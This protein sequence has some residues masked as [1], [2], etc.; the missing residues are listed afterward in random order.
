MSISA[1]IGRDREIIVLDEL[2]EHI[3]K[4]GGALVVRGDAGIGK[5]A[6][7]VEARA[8]AETR[9]LRTM[10]VTGV[11]SESVLPFAGL[12]QLMR[13]VLD[14]ASQL[15]EP[16]QKALLAAFGMA[17]IANSSRFLIALAALELFSDAAAQAPLLLLIEDAQWLDPST[18]EVLA[19]VAR[20]LESEPIV[21]LVAVRDGAQSIFTE[22]GLPELHLKGLD[23]VSS[24]ALL[25]E[26]GWDLDSTPTQRVLQEAQGNPLALLELPVALRDLG[27][28]EGALPLSILPL[29]ARL[30]SAFLDR[31][32]TL[33][34]A[35][36]TFLLVAASDD[37]DDLGEILA[38]ANIMLSSSDIAK[39]ALSSALQSTLVS[40]DGRHLR[41]RHPLVRSAIYQGASA[42][43]RHA[44]H[45]ALATVLSAEPD[46][47]VWHRAASVIGTNDAVAAE[48]EAAAE[49]AEQ[50][51]DVDG[52]VAALER[53][54]Q[55]ATQPARR[56][57]LLLKAALQ[58]AVLGRHGDAVR[59]LRAIEPLQLSARERVQ[60]N[61]YRELYDDRGRAWSGATRLRDFVRIADE[62][63]QDGD[64]DLALRF[65]DDVSLRCY[66]SNPD[67]ETRR[68][69]IASAERLAVPEDAPG[70]IETL[71]LAAPIERGALVLERL[72]RLPPPDSS[73][74]LAMLYL[75]N[76]AGGVG[77]M[78]TSARFLLAAVAGL[79]A[80]GWLGELPKALVSQ[81]YAA[82]HTGNF[83]LAMVAAD[84]AERLARESGLK[85]FEMTAR[86]SRAMLAGLR[87]DEDLAES[88]TNAVERVLIPMGANP[89]LALVQIAH[90]FTALG[91]GHYSDAF[92]HLARIFDP[93]DVAYHAAVRFWAVADLAEAAL[94]SG[95]QN[96]ARAI[97]EAMVPLAALSH[98]PVLRMGL[99]F[100]HAVLSA[101]KASEAH[102]EEALAADLSAW[103]FHRARLLLAYGAWLRRRRRVA[104]SRAPLRAAREVF[105][106]L[107]ATPW[108]ERAR[109][110]LRASGESS[111]QRMPEAW[112]QLSPQELQI[113]QMAAQGL[114]NRE[115]G[116][117]LFLSHRTV[118]YHLY[119]IFPK[120]GITSRAEL[121]SVP[122]IELHL[123][124]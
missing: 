92:D 31:V 94:H 38:A 47:R 72:E 104:E 50:R 114:S 1:L 90:G 25:S 97:V 112:D 113:A 91:A 64:D 77:A 35:T 123:P 79:R 100:A 3:D 81:S 86:A 101:D 106:A 74:P 67:E 58:A 49:R 51:G 19:F 99:L 85:T 24:I 52:A 93:K 65:L 33:P 87:G 70:L 73:D 29:T 119:R 124:A 118:G 111:R 43:M 60:L 5:S 61:W 53:A 102:F 98:S 26:S 11:Q 28:D 20:R 107:G 15:P 7:L 117:R 44:A 109:Q 63:H 46:R 55:L 39:D 96:E 82:I 34:D 57:E 105:D 56:G 78:D 30:E 36:R 62:A 12:H 95:R 76:A 32:A 89:L 41:F 108:S 116:Q 2:L 122:G 88:L 115:I 45:M 16:H 120:L 42:W 71:A 54:G 75:G 103:P 13:P 27:S 17:E 83:Q 18:A 84:E 22:A 121:R 9:G 37:G 110:E 66:W 8:H 59:L 14:H 80:R 69:I 6:L 21:L 40:S 4:R 48:L 68:L 23:E 10:I